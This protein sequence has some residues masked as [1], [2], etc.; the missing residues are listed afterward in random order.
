[1]KP[2]LYLVEGDVME[3]GVAGLGTQRQR[4]IGPR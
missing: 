1:M 3:L 2:P 4:V